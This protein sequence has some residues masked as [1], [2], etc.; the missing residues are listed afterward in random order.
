MS[1]CQKNGSS[2]IKISWHLKRLV[3]ISPI[4][5][6]NWIAAKE[7]CV[8]I[9]IEHGWRKKSVQWARAREREL[10]R[11]RQFIIAFV[12]FVCEVHVFLPISLGHILVGVCFFMVQM[13]AHLHTHIG[14]KIKDSFY[15]FSVVTLI[16][17]TQKRSW[18]WSVLCLLGFFSA[19]V[20]RFCCP[21][22][23]PN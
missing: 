22:N 14:S 11:L 17:F 15:A 3:Y 21:Y 13:C 2:R 23:Q 16:V 20:A 10:S 5:A 7:M 8:L 1:S 6:R 19:H 4:S 12:V 9:V 18:I